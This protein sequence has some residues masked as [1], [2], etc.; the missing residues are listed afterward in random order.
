M[1]YLH[2][3]TSVVQWVDTRR[4]F[5]GKRWKKKF[6]IFEFAIIDK[7]LY[8]KCQLLIYLASIVVIIVIYKS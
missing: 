6:S 4:S 2:I 8:G 3:S 5:L 7:Y 1:L